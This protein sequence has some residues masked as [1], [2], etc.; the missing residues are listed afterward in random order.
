VPPSVSLKR[1]T[2][3]GS[4]EED[5]AGERRIRITPGV[6]GSLPAAAGVGKWGASKLATGPEPWVSPGERRIRITPGVSGPLPAVGKRGA[7]TLATGPEPWLNP[8]ERNSRISAGV[9]GAL[10]P[11]VAAG[12]TKD[13]AEA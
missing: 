11:G 12:V 13:A 7:S 8:G 1:R 10:P 3:E 2:G 5:G 4:T 9:C 6:S